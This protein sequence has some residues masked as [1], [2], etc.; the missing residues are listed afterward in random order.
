MAPHPLTKTHFFQ[1][2]TFLKFKIKAK[3]VFKIE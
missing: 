2:Y 1:K 3:V